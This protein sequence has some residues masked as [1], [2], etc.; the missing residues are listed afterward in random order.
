MPTNVS[1][2][3]NTPVTI[4]LGEKEIKLTALTPGDLGLWER[5]VKDRPLV[6]F[7]EQ[8][9][10]LGDILEKDERQE[11]WQQ[12]KE[13]SA[14]I[15][16]LSDDAAKEVMQ[17]IEGIAF[18]LWL[19]AKHEQPKITYDEALHALTFNREEIENALN[20]VMELEGSEDTEGKLDGAI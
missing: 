19:C 4:M 7:K 14:A 13:D 11:L 8:I 5:W 9:K 2:M 20:Q 18:C 6:R 12:A 15:K 17:S 1:T 16:S 10:L 3:A